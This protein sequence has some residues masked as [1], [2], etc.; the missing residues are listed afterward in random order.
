MGT[1]TEHERSDRR[2]KV[3]I[4]ALALMTFG[5]LGTSIYY[6]NADQHDRLLADMGKLA[7]ERMLGEKLRMEKQ[8]VE[9]I[10]ARDQEKTGRLDGEALIGVL[11]KRVKEAQDRVRDLERR[12]NA[13]TKARK[14]LEALQAEKA[15]LEARLNTALAAERDLQART[16]TLQADR[17]ALAA[18]LDQ[19]RTGAWM[20][21]NAQVE[22]LRG[23][24]Q[25][26][27]VK[28]RNT[29]EMRLAF[30]LPKDLA[31][32]ANFRIVSPS[33]KTYQGNDPAISM[34][35][36][37][38]D[39]EA[40]AS[41]SLIM[42]GPGSEQPARVHLRFEPKEKLE[43]GVYTIDV[44]SGETYLNTVRLSLR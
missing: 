23:K 12:A 3:V 30:D 28:A 8:L 31:S 27:T 42:G 19:Q 38:P 22:A 17:D 18:K 26:L 4:A 21:N 39:G 43:P 20:V 40:T 35:F 32:L 5:A 1:K 10:D 36:E 15:A 13:T 25:K 14:E 9:A 6:Y 33:G 34:S 2:Q 7:N 11:E 24:K 41:L 16:N 44:R 37:A 29:R